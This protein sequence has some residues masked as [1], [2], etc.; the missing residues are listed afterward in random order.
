MQQSA[1]C[2][3]SI[4]YFSGGEC[5]AGRESQRNS[6]GYRLGLASASQHSGCEPTF[7]GCGSCAMHSSFSL[8]SA[9]NFWL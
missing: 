1:V 5:A 9:M 8:A 3:P 6:F 7:W 4:P 2:L